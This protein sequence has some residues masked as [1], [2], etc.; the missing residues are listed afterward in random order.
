MA[1][2]DSARLYAAETQ[3]AI[4]AVRRAC[5][6][7]ASVFN[8]LVKQETLTKDD[9]SPVTVGDFSAQ[10]V[11]NTILGRTFPDDPIVGE[12]DA[13]DLRVDSGKALR[14]RIV[15]LANE[16]LTAE[17]RP[18]EKE[19][20]GLGPNHARTA[21]QLLDA[22]DRGNYDGG[23]TGRIWTLDPIDG[24]KGF[25]RGEQYAVCL[26]LLV[27]ARVELGVIGC[28]N[29]PVTASNPF[30]T[31]GCI[32][33]AVRGQGAY[34]LPLDN[35]FGG[36]RT[37][38]AIPSST[39][40][41]LNFLESVEKAHSKLS[42]NERVGEILGVTRAPTRMDS[43]AKYC[44][45][46]RGDGGVYLR[47]PVGSGY[48]EKI[49]DHAAGSILIEEAGGVISDGRGEPLDFGLGRLLGENYGIVASGKDVHEKVI[50]AIK[51]AKAEEE[52]QS[53]S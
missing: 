7:T 14:D 36:E 9:K 8:K 12:E 31:R 44:A 49:W 48:K 29:L 13:A 11:I 27:D 39:P 51:Q 1:A 32:F 23:P 16:T 30:S 40:E 5:V 17:L 25:L 26:A 22:I 35:A 21:D 50:A 2:N 52:A 47:M 6:L 41:T 19:E 4:A 28:P 45:L 53:R 37:K 18:G 38:L 46:A 15:Q 34:Q 3:V 42:F 33:F 24:T 10:A 43:Q 20:W